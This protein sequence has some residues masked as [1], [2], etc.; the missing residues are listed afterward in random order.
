MFVFPYT[1][2]VN[3][4]EALQFNQML[5]VFSLIL[6]CSP[7]AYLPYTAVIRNQ[8]TCQGNPWVQAQISLCT[9]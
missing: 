5:K 9:E 1:I 8:E 6:T 2:R 4:A 7:Q 3:D